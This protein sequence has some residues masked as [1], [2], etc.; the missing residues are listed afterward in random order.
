MEGTHTGDLL[1]IAPTGTRIRLEGATFTT[2]DDT[3]MV[4]ED[5]HHVDYAS[6]FAQ[7][8]VQR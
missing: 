8:G 7:L 1:G 6:L 4:I 5:I 2:I 3:G